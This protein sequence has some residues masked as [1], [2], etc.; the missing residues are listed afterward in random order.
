MKGAL[1]MCGAGVLL[2]LALTPRGAEACARC[3][4]EEPKCEAAN[5]RTC[6]VTQVSPIHYTCT[7]SYAECAWV[8]NAL[9]VSI[10]G[11][12][13]RAESGPDSGIRDADGERRGCHGLVLE[14][15]VS[16][17]RGAQV[18]RESSRIVI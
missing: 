2:L 9:E 7:E 15:S 13:A 12:L 14:R 16:A 10:D 18:R 1:L 8:Y 6:Q 11:S 17:E 3:N 5:W 4:R